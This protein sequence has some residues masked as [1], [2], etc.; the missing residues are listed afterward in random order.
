MNQGGMAV[1]AAQRP[2]C[3][4]TGG[5][6][7]ARLVFAALRPGG[8]RSGLKQANSRA[9]ARLSPAAKTQV[10]V[11][12]RK[13]RPSRRD[14]TRKHLL[15]HCF[16]LLIL[17]QIGLHRMSGRSDSIEC[18]IWGDTSVRVWDRR[19]LTKAV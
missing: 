11:L 8:P 2:L 17:F 13:S 9:L 10:S 1:E 12:A 19:A 3:H 5:A 14:K 18:P 6:R 15:S 7:S 16:C 4:R